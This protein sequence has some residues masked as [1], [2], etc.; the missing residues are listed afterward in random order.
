MTDFDDWSDFYNYLRSSVMISNEPKVIVCNPEDKIE[1][2]KNLPD[3][4]KKRFEIKA[5]SVIESGK[6]YIID[7][8]LLEP[9]PY[10][11]L[12]PPL[13]NEFTDNNG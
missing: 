1:F 13:L 11:D 6:A 7:K 9:R 5:N 12:E 8:A 3:D 2:E 4:I 10:F